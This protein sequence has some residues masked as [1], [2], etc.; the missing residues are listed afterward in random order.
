VLNHHD[1]AENCCKRAIAILEKA[2]GDPRE[3]ATALDD[4]AAV[5]K[6]MGK[7]DDAAKLEARAVTLRDSVK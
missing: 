2:N 7:A 6:N 1:E 4:Y 5:L 3:L